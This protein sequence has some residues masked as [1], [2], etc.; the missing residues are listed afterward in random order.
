MSMIDKKNEIK[1]FLAIDYGKSKVGLALA[2]NETK[3]AFPYKTLDNDKNFFQELAEIITKRNISLV[4]IGLPSY[5]N[6]EKVEYESEKVGKIIKD[7]IGVEVEYQNEMFTTQM[8][9]KNL[10]EKGVKGIKKYDDAEAARIIL[11]SWLDK[12]V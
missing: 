9:Q 10:I 7:K 1:N 8:A 12:E 3:I 5:I 6:K 4:I 2:D 11:Q